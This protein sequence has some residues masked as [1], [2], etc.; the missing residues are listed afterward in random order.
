MSKEIVHA[1]G[2]LKLAA[3][4]IKRKKLSLKESCLSIGFVNENRFCEF[5]P[6]KN[7]LTPM[8]VK[9]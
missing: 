4:I 3:D 5:L 9:F 6:R 7:D 8:R 2:R 1:F